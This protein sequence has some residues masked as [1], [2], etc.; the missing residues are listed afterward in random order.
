MFDRL[1]HLL[2]HHPEWDERETIRLRLSRQAPTPA[3]LAEI[4]MIFARRF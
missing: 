1:R 4:E 2:P 3:Q